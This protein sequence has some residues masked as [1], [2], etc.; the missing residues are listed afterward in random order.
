MEAAS[1]E[2][3]ICAHVEEKLLDITDEALFDY[4]LVFMHGRTAFQLTNQ[5]RQQLRQY[6]ERGGMLMADSICASPAFSESFRHELAEICPDR[7]VE[8]IPAADPLWSTKF[9]GFD[10]ATVSRRDVEAAPPA[11][12]PPK[13]TVRK[14]PP[15]LEGVKIDGR[16]GVIFSP[17]DLSCALEKLDSPECRGYSR[18]DAARIVMNVLLYACSS[19]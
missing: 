9:G 11:G 13:M 17:Y 4:H 5:Q 14:V 15:E 10:L 8:P 7:K 19:K 12:G 6:L 2:M 3:K 1:R 18:D 16:W